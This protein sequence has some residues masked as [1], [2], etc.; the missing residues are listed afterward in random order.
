MVAEG[1]RELSADEKYEERFK[2]WM[3]PANVQ[4]ASAEAEKAYK[5]R[6]QLI[7]DAVE[8]KKPRRIPVCPNIG[9]FPANYA[10]ITAQEAMYDYQ[11]LGMAWK[12][13]HEDFQ[14][15]CLA[16]CLL[17]T[18]GRVFDIL[19]YRLYR[20]PGHGTPPNTPYQ[21]VEGEYM[22]ED[23]YDALIRDP[24]AYWMRCYLPR[25]FGA[26]EGWKNLAPLTDLVEM[27]FAGAFMVPIG[28][29]E[30]QRSFEALLEAGRAAVEWIQAAGAIDAEVM[31]TYG[32]P[33]LIGGFSKAP[34]DTLGDTLRGTKGIML[35][36][37][38]RPGKLLKAMEK[39][40]P[41]MVEMGVR[42]ATM[43]GH[44]MVFIPL[45]KG[46]DGFLSRNDFAKFYWPTLKEVLLGLTAEGLV[47]LVF[48]EGSYNQRLD[49]LADPDLPQGRIV[50]MFDQTDMVKVKEV[51]GGGACFAGNVPVALLK[52]GTPSEVHAYVRDLIEKVG[53]DGG[54]ILTTGGVV[55]EAEPDNFRAM[56]EAGKEYG[57]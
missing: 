21:C 20:W 52:A 11:K 31:G 23:E 37:Y 38:R 26:L 24:S 16:S 45:H 57:A 39:L 17:A 56:I 13:Y 46:A 55:D 19:D 15:D 50:W 25:V 33:S 49:F 51:L 44:P 32:V 2:A 34:F 35:D 14:P 28:M 43:A 40:V 41:I 6:V 18:P 4:F 47:P 8:L 3:S 1:R 29:P 42:T 9:F 7:K 30:V 48:V 36:V 53:Q 27:A 5:E 22:L 54:F 10:G 12:K